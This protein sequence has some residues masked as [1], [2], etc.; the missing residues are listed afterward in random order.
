M[1]ITQLTINIIV[2]LLPGIFGTFILEKLY[3]QEKNRKQNIC[4]IDNTYR[5]CIL[6]FAI[7]NP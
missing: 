1:E 3:F 2:L 4:C 5:I 7:S 6:F